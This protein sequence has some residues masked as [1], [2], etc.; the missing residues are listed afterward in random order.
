MHS[1]GA[2]TLCQ[3]LW[4]EDCANGTLFEEHHPLIHSC[5][6][7]GASGYAIKMEG[8]ISHGEIYDC[9]AGDSGD[10]TIQINTTAST[11]GIKMIDTIVVGSG[12][13][14]ISLSATTR[15]FIS[16]SGNI[17]KY[18]TLG[19]FNDLGTDNVL[20]IEGSSTGGLDEN[21]LHIGLDSYSNKDDWKADVSGGTGDCPTALENATAVWEF[22]LSAPPE[23]TVYPIMYPQGSD[24]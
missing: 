23:G 8:D 4:F 11:G 2:F 16:Q 1:T 18:N 3:N 9:T 21:A 15:K 6:V 22:D 14:G 20:N 7:H 19:D 13:Y 5:K 17:V 12:G 24:Q 10:T